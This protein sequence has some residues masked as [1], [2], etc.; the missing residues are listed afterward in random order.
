MDSLEAIL[1]RVHRAPEDGAGAEEEEEEEEED[2][3]YDDDY[4]SCEDA[5]Q[6]YQ[7]PL[8]SDADARAQDVH[9][10]MI[11]V[12]QRLRDTGLSDQAIRFVQQAAATA[13]RLEWRP[14]N[15]AGAGMCAARAGKR[16][17]FELV[18]DASRLRVSGDAL[19]LVIGAL[20]YA[21][22]GRPDADVYARGWTSDALERNYTLA[23]RAA[24]QLRT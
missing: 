9:D 18:A 19:L 24:L 10:T 12:V 3:A 6:S 14:L 2:A 15:G 21:S 23:K 17:K 4:S 22:F 13:A 20:Y 1:A 7:A 5:E 11:A 8:S 16:A